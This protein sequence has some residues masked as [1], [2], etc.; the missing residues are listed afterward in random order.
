MAQVTCTARHSYAGRAANTCQSLRS[1]NCY[2]CFDL[3]FL[4]EVAS[5]NLGNPQNNHLQKT[6]VDLLS[7]GKIRLVLPQI[8]DKPMPPST[9]PDDCDLS[10]AGSK[11]MM[12]LAK[13]RISLPEIVKN[14]GVIITNYTFFALFT[15][16]HPFV[17]TQNS[18]FHEGPDEKEI[19]QSPTAA[20]QRNR[21]D[22]RRQK[23]LDVRFT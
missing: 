22:P 12:T 8:F 10:T 20:F 15:F 17:T 18:H 2:V 3:S 19:A 13:A 14:T 7:T 9:R 4:E 16:C 11:A 21:R 5:K 1:R 6:M 23:S